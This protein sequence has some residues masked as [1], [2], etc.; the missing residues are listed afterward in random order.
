MYRRTNSLLSKMAKY[1]YQFSNYPEIV[2]NF[3]HHLGGKWENDTC[4]F[5]EKYGKGTVEAH[6]L[7]EGLSVAIGKFGL[8]QPLELIR[9]GSLNPDMIAIDF[10]LSENASLYLDAVAE[11]DKTRILEYGVHFFSTD[12]ASSYTFESGMNF[13]Q[14]NLLFTKEFFQKYFVTEDEHYPSPLRNLMELKSFYSYYKLTPEL[15]RA[16]QDISALC[17]NRH[18]RKTFLFGKTMEALS[19]FFSNIRNERSYDLTSKE[20]SAFL[21]LKEEILSFPHLVYSLENLEH[22]TGMS[23]KKLQ[24]ICQTLFC[25]SVG[26]FVIEIKMEAAKEYLAQGYSVS[27]AGYKIGYT[28]LSHFSQSF[29]KTFGYLPSKLVYR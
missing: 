9:E 2:E 3:A 20:V 15:S 28:N 11:S 6:Y 19:L 14:F 13:F 8:N 24:R 29:R 16:L 22:K 12:Q 21:S 10:H 17:R 1:T 27:E 25:Q 26:Q 5:P 4:H 7:S 23:R 18:F